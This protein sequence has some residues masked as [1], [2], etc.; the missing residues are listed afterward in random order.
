M[1]DADKKEIRLLRLLDPDKQ[2]AGTLWK[3]HAGP[4]P[5]LASHH[6]TTCAGKPAA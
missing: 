6:P 1:T 2:S 4:R 3:M 5:D